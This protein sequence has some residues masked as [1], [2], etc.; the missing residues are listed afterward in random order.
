MK[1]KTRLYRIW[2]NMVT[3]CT[4]PNFPAYRN[5]GGRGVGIFPEWRKSFAAFARDVG[6]PPTSTHSIDRWPNRDGNYEPGNVRW[7]TREEQG[8]NRRGLIEVDFQGRRVCLTEAAEMAGLAYGTVYYR[9][10]KHGWPIEKALSTPAV[11]GQKV[12]P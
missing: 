8:R 5:Y 10:V 7:A 9:I 3:R 2:T 4:N 1:K 11:V 12:M 6:E